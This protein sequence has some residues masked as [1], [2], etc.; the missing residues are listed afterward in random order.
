MKTYVDD[1]PCP[2]FDVGV[3]EAL[4]DKLHVA[5]LIVGQC[6]RAIVRR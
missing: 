6:L 2:A 3:D 4:R 1:R 5:Q